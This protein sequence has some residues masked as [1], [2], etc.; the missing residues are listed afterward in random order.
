VLLIERDSSQIGWTNAQSHFR[1]GVFLAK[2]DSVQMEE[3]TCA[4]AAHVRNQIEQIHVA[5]SWLFEDLHFHLSNDSIVVPNMDVAIRKS[6]AAFLQSFEV[7]NTIG[8]GFIEKAILSEATDERVSSEL[9]AHVTVRFQVDWL[10]CEIVVL[11]V[12]YLKTTLT[13]RD[14]GR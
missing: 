5:D 6:G 12:R 7:I 4:R 14:G 3:S 10:K 9:N 2:R 13:I 11:C 1:Y 8:T